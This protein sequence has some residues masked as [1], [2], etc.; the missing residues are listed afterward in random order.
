MIPPAKQPT[1]LPIPLEHGQSCHA[2]LPTMKSDSHEK[3]VFA[4]M[5]IIS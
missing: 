3:E 1:Y 4:D 5:Q 2:E